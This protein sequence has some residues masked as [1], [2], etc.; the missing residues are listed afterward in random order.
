MSILIKLIYVIYINI[1]ELEDVLK[2]CVYQA[3]MHGIL[4]ELYLVCE[5]YKVGCTLFPLEI[6]HTKT[7][8]KTFPVY[9]DNNLYV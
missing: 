8:T 6:N 5:A 1:N 9:T 7:M 3:T 4:T 2:Y